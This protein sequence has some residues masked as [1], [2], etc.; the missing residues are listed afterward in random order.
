MK[1][2]VRMTRRLWAM[3]AGLLRDSAG[4]VLVYAAIAAPVLIGAAA[5]SVDIG[6]WYANKRLAQS[7]ADSAALAGSL[8]VIRSGGDASLISAIALSNAATNGFTT[9]RGDT[10]T[11]NY[12]PASGPNVGSTVA[13]EVIVS[14]PGRRL[15]SQVLFGGNTNI[16]A[17][18][19]ATADINNS[20]VWALNPSSPSSLR[21]S[22]NAQ[23]LL[24]CGILINSAS[25]TGLFQSGSGCIEASVIKVVGGF[26]VAC[27]D[28]NPLAGVTAFQDPLA[29][30]PAP[31]YGACD[32]SAN[33]TVNG[34]DTRRLTPGTY[35]GKIKV[36]ANGTLEFDPGLYVL[37]GAGLDVSG[38]GTVNGS[39]VSF[40]LTQNSGVPDAITIS[41]GA[42]VTLSADAGGPLPGILF[43]HDRDSSGNV[44]HRFTG[45]ANME[46]SGVLYFPSQTINFSG[47]SNL[48]DS[49]AMII[50]DTV[51]FTGSSVVDLN[52]VTT[53]NPLLAQATLLE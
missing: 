46:L 17:R 20:C 6:L 18:A 26:S 19:V 31:T 35:C 47:G 53:T 29:A 39:D 4:S 11:V 22:G 30:L 44:T 7:A 28:P 21:V 50:A 12:P 52:N 14:R 2:Y 43:Y 1:G 13:V 36:S 38:Q 45:G 25:A 37:D 9:G 8:E 41:G 10:I 49:Q 32:F 48:N 33:I 3:L 24:N 5:L 27:A 40:Y 34:G 15:L 23:V 42:T 16:V 51:E